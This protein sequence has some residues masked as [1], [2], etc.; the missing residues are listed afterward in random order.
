M[1]S[2]LILF[3]RLCQL[4]P[5]ADKQTP[6][7]TARLRRWDSANR[8]PGGLLGGSTF[9]RRVPGMGMAVAIP[10]LLPAFPRRDLRG[11]NRTHL[12]YPLTTVPHAAR[13]LNAIDYARWAWRA[14]T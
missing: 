13:Y 5:V 7:G 12:P 14:M 8:L 3:A 11:G 4:M 2:V 6:R 1:S 10:H 9:Q